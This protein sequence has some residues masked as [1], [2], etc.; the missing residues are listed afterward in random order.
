[1]NIDKLIFFVYVCYKIALV[2]IILIA[3]AF[4]FR[5]VIV[6]IILIS[7]G[8]FVI[9]CVFDIKVLKEK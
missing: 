8:G 4:L 7:K 9:F 2:A 1:M 3:D 6:F 5:N